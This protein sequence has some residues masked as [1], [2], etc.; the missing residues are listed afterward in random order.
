MRYHLTSI[1]VDTTKNARHPMNAPPLAR[2]QSLLMHGW[3]IAG[4]VQ[5]G[6]RLAIFMRTKKRWHW[7]FWT[8]EEPPEGR[9][10][11]AVHYH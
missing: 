2:L 4:T 8:K 3:D 9:K 5:L 10:S 11:Y 6:D 7:R 1:W